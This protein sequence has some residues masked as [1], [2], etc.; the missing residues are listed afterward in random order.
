ML[1]YFNNICLSKFI[2]FSCSNYPAI[3]SISIFFY[4]QNKNYKKNLL[5]FFL[6]LNLIFGAIFFVKKKNS[7]KSASILVNILKLVLKKKKVYAFL[8]TFLLYLPFSN[9][10]P[11]Q[12]FKEIIFNV[13]SVKTVQYLRVTFFAFPPISELDKFYQ[14]FE[15]FYTLVSTFKFQCDFHLLNPVVFGFNFI[16]RFF[17]FPCKV[18]LS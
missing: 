12:L 17:R 4:Y 18:F 3:H 14:D 9:V 5:L 15:N 6:I 8:F 10:V 16:L 13:V 11:R 7:I 2:F 1:F